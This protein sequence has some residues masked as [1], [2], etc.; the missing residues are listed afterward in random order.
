[1]EKYRAEKED[2]DYK[3]L[4]LELQFKMWRLGKTQRRWQVNKVM[5]QIWTAAV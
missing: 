2:K 1:M 5:K 4:G 3:R